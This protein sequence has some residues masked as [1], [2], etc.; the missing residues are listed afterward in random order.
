MFWDILK[1][2]HCM[3]NQQEQNHHTH[4]LHAYKISHI[5]N[6]LIQNREENPENSKLSQV[7]SNYNDKEEVQ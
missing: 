7:K 3:R 4:A 5:N 6:K 1:T 2:F